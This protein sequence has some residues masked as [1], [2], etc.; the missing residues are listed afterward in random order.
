MSTLDSL[1]SK[2]LLS[3]SAICS[4]FSTTNAEDGARAV[5]V[6]IEDHKFQPKNYWNGRWRSVWT[7][8]V[9]GNQTEVAG[10]LKVQVHY[11]EDGNVHLVSAK[12]VKESIPLTVRQSKQ[13][14]IR[15]C[16]I[17][18]CLQSETAFAKSLVKLLEDSESDYQTAISDNY[19]TM[20][21]TTFKALRRQLPVT[22]TKLDWNKL[23]GYSIG[24][25]LRNQ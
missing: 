16:L 24:R 14:I 3:M 22:R 4:T 11:Y 15:P 6:C 17:F 2:S 10:L 12:D 23:V 18:F 25:E 5:V 7:I 13:H 19:I 8:S 20:S 1:R 21:D 9:S